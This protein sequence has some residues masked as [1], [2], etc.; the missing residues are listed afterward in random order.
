MAIVNNDK[1]SAPA[2]PARRA[3]VSPQVTDLPRLTELTLQ[4]GSGIPGG[5]STAGGG[6]TVIP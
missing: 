3:W 5:G 4:T 6:S 1:K 2:M